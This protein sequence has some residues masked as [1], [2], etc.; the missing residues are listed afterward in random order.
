[1]DANV[2]ESCSHYLGMP[3]ISNKFASYGPIS[4]ENVVSHWLEYCRRGMH[5]I[6]HVGTV[7]SLKLFHIRMEALRARIIWSLWLVLCGIRRCNHIYRTRPSNLFL[8]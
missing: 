2:V 1:M 6:K 7:P 3:P 4:K 5:N 8:K